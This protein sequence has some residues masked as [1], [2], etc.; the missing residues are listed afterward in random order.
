MILLKSQRRNI[1]LN[2]R[3]FIE[4]KIGDAK[5][6]VVTKNHGV[7]T[8]NK[9]IEEGIT[10]IGE[11]RVQVLLHK[12]ERIKGNVKIHF[13]GHLQRNKVKY[14]IG[15]ADLIHSVDSL[16]LAQKIDEEALKKGI[17]QDILI[18]VNIANEKQKY[19]FDSDELKNVFDAV[20]LL[21]NIRVQGLMLIA[22]NTSEISELKTYFKKMKVLFDY[23][24]N[25][26]Y[27]NV[28]MKYLSMG[29][30][31]DYELAVEHGSNM[32]RIGRAFFSGGSNNE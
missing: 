9:L 20:S 19:G 8:I 3:K 6:I 16:R 28:Y 7:D 22:P 23:Y 21:N 32:V 10:D 25:N 29:M 11:N 24:A 31:N 26:N 27:N 30:S 1:Y 5:L 18:Q 13:I 17:I 14:I 2:N 15:I 12:Y 4:D